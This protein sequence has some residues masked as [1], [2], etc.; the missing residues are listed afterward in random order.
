MAYVSIWTRVAVIL[1]LKLFPCLPMLL[2]TDL[3]LYPILVF[4]VSLRDV[5]CVSILNIVFYSDLLRC[6]MSPGKVAL[7]HL[8][9][10]IT[11]I[12]Y[13]YLSYA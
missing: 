7:I 1:S 5:S 4:A 2:F 9:I 8:F 12:I 10:I 3:L 6:L 11:I 13:K